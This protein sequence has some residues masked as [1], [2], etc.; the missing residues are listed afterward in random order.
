MKRFSVNK[1]DVNLK[2]VFVGACLQMY[3]NNDDIT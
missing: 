2:Y 1:F 3:L